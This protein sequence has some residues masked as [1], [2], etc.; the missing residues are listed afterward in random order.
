MVEEKQISGIETRIQMK[1]IIY[2]LLV[3]D[4]LHLYALLCDHLILISH[5]QLL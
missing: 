3:H 5:F 4:A 2:L 1:M